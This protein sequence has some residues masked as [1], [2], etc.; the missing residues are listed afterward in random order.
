MPI[1]LHT[2]GSSPRC[3]Q[4]GAT[5]AFVNAFCLNCGEKLLKQYTLGAYDPIYDDPAP[6]PKN[7]KKQSASGYWAGVLGQSAVSAPKSTRQLPDPAPARPAPHKHPDHFCPHCVDCHPLAHH[8]CFEYDEPN[9]LLKAVSFVVPPIGLYVSTV[10]RKSHPLLAAKAARS[11]VFGMMF[12]CTL[13]AA[14]APIGHAVEAIHPLQSR[15]VVWLNSVLESTVP[16][17]DVKSTSANPSVA[18]V[19][20][21]S[22]R[23]ATPHMRRHRHL[24][25][26]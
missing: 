19:H 16:K 5:N 10:N 15:P 22:G 2:G 1:N 25:S 24:D 23:S 9:S 13:A 17:T 14:R 26:E 12:L 21:T 18:T 6:K 3:P 20:H 11:A 8:H 7:A 4:C